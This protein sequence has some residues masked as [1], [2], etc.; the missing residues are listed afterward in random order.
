ML[1]RD[2]CREEFRR[3]KMEALNLSQFLETELAAIDSALH[4]PD[5]SYITL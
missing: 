5:S 2:R 1:K 4:H 3:L